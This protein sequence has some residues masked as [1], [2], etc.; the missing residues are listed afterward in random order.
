MSNTKLYGKVGSPRVPAGTAAPGGSRLR[1][2]PG[3]SGRR[4]A[5]A[6][7]RAAAG[8]PRH[9]PAAAAGGGRG[10]RRDLAEPMSNSWLPFT[11][12]LG[13]RAAI[14]DFL[15]ARTGHR[16]DP[17]REIVIT[18]GGMEG[19]S[20]SLLASSTPATRSSLTDPTY[21]GIVNRVR[22]AGGVPRFAPFRRWT[23]SGGSTA[24]RWPPRSARRRAR[25]C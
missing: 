18:C 12:D 23:A 1:H 8:E 5:A 19:C 20:T 4:G 2:R 6:R 9:R 14:S 10:H 25:C 21:A 22:L 16:F 17:E 11:G 7:T 3:R 13:L 24:T 15:A